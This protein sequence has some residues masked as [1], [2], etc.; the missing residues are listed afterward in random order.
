[1][2]RVLIAGLVGGVVYYIW[3]MLC[4]MALPVHD[5]AMQ[6]LPGESIFSEFLVEQDVK[7]GVYFAPYTDS[8]EDMGNPESEWYLSHVEG[9]VY[10][11]FVRQQGHQPMSPALM[12]TGFGLD[13]AA[14]L[15][16]ACLL[17]GAAGGCCSGYAARVGFVLGLGLFASIVSHGAMWNWMNVPTD[18]TLSMI[19]EVTVGW[20]LA[21]LVIA[22]I[23]VPAKPKVVELEKSADGESE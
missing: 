6:P 18:H 7:T 4:W 16:A 2:L 14:A 19:F 15:L 9:P 17:Y 8:M 5:N 12:A 1:M 23:V 3:L 20:L 21:G 13:V 11:L 22:A 10:T